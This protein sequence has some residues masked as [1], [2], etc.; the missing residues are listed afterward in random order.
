M[1]TIHKLTGNYNLEIL[2]GE[3]DSQT[4]IHVHRR[5]QGF[6]IIDRRTAQD[7]RLSWEARGLLVYLLSLPLNWQIRVSHLKQQ[8]GAGRDAVRR[9]LKELEQFGYVAGFSKP[10]N[11]EG[12]KLARQITVYESPELNSHFHIAN[13]PAPETPSLV[14]PEPE[15]PATA[16]PSPE[17][18][19][20]Y[21][22]DSEQNKKVQ[23]THPQT[24]EVVVAVGSKFSLEQC[25]QYA[26]HLHETGQ[27]IN[28]PGGFAVKL[29]RTGEQDALIE[30]FFG[31]PPEVTLKDADPRCKLCL[32][33]GKEHVFD[34]S[35][36]ILGV[37]PT[38]CACRKQT[39]ETVQDQRKE[40]MVA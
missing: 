21:K 38:S 26:R 16:Q 36:K 24:T 19:S 25:Q 33:T 27:G 29:H 12:G 22:I 34:D 1:A 28:N 20:P 30:R 17:K 2:D 4:V 9:V 11:K 39:S 13:Q 35:G 37:K 23:I 31:A 15:N 40:Q 5:E 10:M 3:S 8:G 18:P 14:Q 32:G 7:E 6:V